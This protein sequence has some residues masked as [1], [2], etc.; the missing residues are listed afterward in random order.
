MN[1][2]GREA[3]AFRPFFRHSRMCNKSR[4]FS[5]VELIVTIAVLGIVAVI[6]VPRFMGRDGFDSR[7]F[8][9]QS[10]AV[11]RL[12]QKTA[13]AWRRDVFVCV[14]TSTVTAGTAAG[15]AT[16]LTFQTSGG[17]AVATAP[18]G[19]MLNAVNFSFDRLGRASAAVTLTFT[20]S[21][22]GDPARQIAVTA[23]TGYVAV[24]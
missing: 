20:S 12:A 10:A 3:Q 18:S 6:A 19:V 1:R 2:S 17:N 16:P 13:V 15:C 14:T 21:I 7:G 4:G 9:D 23:E 5:L 8:Y 24:N 11:I 22:A